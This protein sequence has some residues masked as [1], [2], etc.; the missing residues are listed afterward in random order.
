MFSRDRFVL[1][2]L[3]RG[4]LAETDDQLAAHGVSHTPEG[5]NAGAVLTA[6]EACDGGGACPDPPSKFVL[7]G[8]KFQTKANH[9]TGNRSY[10]SNC[11]RVR[12]YRASPVTASSI[13]AR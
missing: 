11:S 2:P 12:R 1:L 13:A 8:A 9:Q 4:H 10:G 6:L 5:L 7:S 3:R